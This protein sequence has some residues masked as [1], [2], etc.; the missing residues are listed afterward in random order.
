MIDC[1]RATPRR[2]RPPAKRSTR[3]SSSAHVVLRSRQTS[4]TFDGEF[5]AW[6]LKIID[7]FGERLV[8]TF[9]ISTRPGRVNAPHHA[10]LF[11]ERRPRA[12]ALRQLL[13]HGWQI[14]S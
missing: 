7:G 5:A 8:K 14:S 10:G 9:A 12:E 4:A 1:F 6:I 13:Q 11:R 3:S 2:E